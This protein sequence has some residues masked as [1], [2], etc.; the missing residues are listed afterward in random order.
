MLG[1]I[2]PIQYFWQFSFHEKN[3][4][5]KNRENTTVLHFSAFGNFNFTRKTSSKKKSWKYNGFAL[6]CFWQL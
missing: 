3:N 2:G 4:F 5:E 6:S 1:P